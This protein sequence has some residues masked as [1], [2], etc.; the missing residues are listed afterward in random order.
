M[1]TREYYKRHDDGGNR[2]ILKRP[3][4]LTPADYKNLLTEYVRHCSEKATYFPYNH[5]GNAAAAT[6]CDHKVDCSD[7][8]VVS[9][10]TK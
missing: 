8:V 5:P 3:S 7:S 10:V 2:V 9:I 4:S 1:I 6:L